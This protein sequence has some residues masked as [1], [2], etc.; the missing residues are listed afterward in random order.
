MTKK[1][2]L[3]ADSGSTKTDWC[4]ISASGRKKYESTAGMNPYFM[5]ESDMLQLL[6]EQLSFSHSKTPI[7]EV[8][9]Y[10][11]GLGQRPMQKK[12]TSVLKTSFP[13][14]VISVQTDLLG[15]AR[16]CCGEKEGIVCI[17]GTGSNSCFK[18]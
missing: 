15:A 16:A 5:Q 11:A 3:I 6:K 12:M 2:I 4:L 13:G 8:H 10:G 14:A 17:L 1:N 18:N 9:F 7:Y